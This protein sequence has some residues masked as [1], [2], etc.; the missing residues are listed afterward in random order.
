MN[1]NSKLGTTQAVLFI[2]IVMIN[3]IILNFPKKIILD[4][5]TG[6][7]VNLIYIGI[8]VILFCLLLS[9]L[10]K[11]FETYDIVDV[12]EFLGGKFLKILIGIIYIAIFL[13]TA[14]TVTIDFSSMLKSIYFN[15]SPILFILLFFLIALVVSNLIGF[16]SIIKANCLI[17]PFMLVSILLILFGTSKEFVFQRLTPIL[18]YG[19]K[20]TFL[21][22]T[23][24]I[25]AFSGFT[26][27]YFIMPLLKEKEN[28]KKISIISM[29]ISWV[30]LFLS[31]SS[32]LLVLPFITYTEELNSLYLITRLV[33]YGDFLQRT[34]A[35]FIF[36]WILS[37]MSY[38]SIVSF[39]IITIT[40]KIANITNE[41]PLI[42]PYACIILGL[43]LI[44]T[45]IIDLNFL[46]NNI[47]KYST[48]IIN[49]IVCPIILILA[50]LKKK[51]M[52]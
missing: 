36:L 44:P 45:D 4:T 50:N 34:D 43:C 13:L 8:I 29:V 20:K 47:Y 32:L 39:F 7:L 15:S 27:L 9:K 28:F 2:L 3:K 41:K 24:N 31:V 18:G 14:S 26:Y 5:G 48:I 21:L 6:S 46:E 23:S 10:F 38:L 17:M 1:N 19:Y 33:K 22:G 30:F 51:R 11:K 49:F 25:F 35:L 42:F 52:T 40:K 37:T 12:S 16:K